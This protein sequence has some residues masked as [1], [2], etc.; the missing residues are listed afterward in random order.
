MAHHRF[1]LGQVRRQQRRAAIALEIGPFRIDQ[2]RHLGGAR[3][4]DHALHLAER[5][6]GV[7]GQHQRADL[8]QRLLNALQHRLRINVG[9]A[10]FE[11]ETDQLLVAR[12]HAQL[13]N[14]RMGR[15]RDEVAAHVDFIQ[16]GAQ[17]PR[18]IVDAG[19]AHQTGSGA[20]RSDVHRHVSRAA[21]TLFDGIDLDHRHRGFR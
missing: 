6:L 13:G 10:F 12:Q 7:I 9:E 8:R 21:G 20:Q 11:V 1:E 16:L 5:A 2:H 3:Q 19:Q 15:H 14:G 18:R 4:L 17:R